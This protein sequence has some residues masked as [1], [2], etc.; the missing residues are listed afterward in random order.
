MPASPDEFDSEYAA[1][2]SGRR[3]GKPANSGAAPVLRAS[4]HRLGWSALIALNLLVVVGGIGVLWPSLQMAGK[5]LAFG[6]VAAVLVLSLT[7]L[8]LLRSMLRKN[9]SSSIRRE[10]KELALNRDERE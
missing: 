2:D 3:R 7:P 10:E 9:A 8:V 1:P 6:M 4:S 5:A